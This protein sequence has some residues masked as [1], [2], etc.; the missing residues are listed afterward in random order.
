M[1]KIELSEVEDFIRDNI[2]TFHRR[3]LETLK[4]INLENLLKRKNPFL[5]KAKNLATAKELIT[6]FLDAILSSSEEEIFGNFLEDLAI[7]VAQITLNAIKSTSAGI[8]FEFVKNKSR[9]LVSVKS[10]PDWGNSSQW[11]QIRANFGAAKKVLM[12]SPHVENVLFV[13]GACYG[14]R[15]PSVRYDVIVQLCG[16]SFWYFL[17]GDEMFY[18]RVVEPLGYK[19][20]ELNSSFQVEKSEVLDKL[21][22]DFGEKFCNDEGEILWDRLISFNSTNMNEETRSLIH[23]LLNF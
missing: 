20:R 21:V 9:Y 19:A 5:F 8:D 12:Q 14:S 10:G 18:V 6:S 4:K 15:K 23:N 11:K 1:N 22:G 3:R 13:V 7:F 16:Q 17:T 2:E